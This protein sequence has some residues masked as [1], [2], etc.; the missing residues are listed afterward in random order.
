MRGKVGRL[1]VWCGVI[2]GL[3]LG[4]AGCGVEQAPACAQ[5]VECAA[6]YSTV[7][8]L[9]E[10]D[11]TAYQADGSCWEDAELATKCELACEEAL[12][13]LNAA[14]RVAGED[15]GACAPEES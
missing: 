15:S 13:A 5:Y 4:A 3:G 7:F 8:D 2:G 10:P 6:H 1:S 9:D 14:L 11:V 12:A